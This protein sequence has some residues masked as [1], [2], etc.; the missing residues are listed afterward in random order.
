VSSDRFWIRLGAA[1]NVDLTVN[2]RPVERLPP[3]TID[4][5]A[6]ANSVQTAG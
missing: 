6:T 5:I 2:D 1:S 3:G 4:L